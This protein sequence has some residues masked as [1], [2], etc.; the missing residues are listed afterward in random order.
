MEKIPT[1]E[2]FWLSKRPQL[3]HAKIAKEFA[4]L[5]VTAALQAATYN[6]EYYEE[7]YD[8][9]QTRYVDESSILNAYPLEN[10]K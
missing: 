9:S 2:E 6:I 1:A 10:I 3:S 8:D 7:P 4:K 5:H